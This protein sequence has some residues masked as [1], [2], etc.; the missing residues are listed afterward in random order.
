LSFCPFASPPTEDDAERNAY[1]LAA[2]DDGSV[3]LH[4][5]RA[6]VRGNRQTHYS[7]DADSM[8]LKRYLFFYS[9]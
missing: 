1:F 7:S 3:R 8:R 4:S 5:V 6:E 2:C 9:K